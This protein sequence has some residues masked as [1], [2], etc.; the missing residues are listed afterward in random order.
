MQEHDLSFVRAEMAIA[1]ARRRGTRRRKLARK[2]LFAS[3]TD[4][5][6]TILGVLLIVWLIPPFINWAFVQAVWSGADR[7]A[8]TTTAQ[9]GVQPE[10]W[11]G[12]C[13]AFVGSKF[14]QFM[15]GRYPIDE[16]WRAILVAL[17]F[18]ALLLP[19]LIPRIPYKGWNAFVFF[20]VFPIVAYV[21]LVGGTLGLRYV[22]TD[23]WGGLLVT[24]V[25]SF[26]GI[27][28][29]CRSASCWRSGGDRSCRSSRCCR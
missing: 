4:T 3:P 21:L 28:V 14:S 29:R 17:L 10:G 7:A 24:M 16:R 8:C 1:A 6:L 9:G 2:N 20:I 13:W 11:S 15:F 27:T 5:A 26:V 25:L 12:A 19:L 23:L 22:P 18:V